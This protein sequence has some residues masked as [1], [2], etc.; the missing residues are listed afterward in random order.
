M[1]QK[2]SPLSLRR[3]EAVIQRE[4]SQL[5]LRGLVGVLLGAAE[6][7]HGFSNLGLESVWRLKQVKHLSLVHLQKHA[8]HLGSL[9]VFQLLNKWIQALAKYLDGRDYLQYQKTD[10][11]N[12][13]SISK[14]SY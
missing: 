1:V 7:L 3:D 5:L 13:H 2:L 14:Q 8:G 4:R 6:N 9:L 12:G 10:S 11:T